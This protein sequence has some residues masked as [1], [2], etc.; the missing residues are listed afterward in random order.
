MLADRVDVGLDVGSEMRQAV[1]MDINPEDNE[2]L[3]I[4]VLC[5]LLGYIV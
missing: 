3:L 5:I 2:C 4:D 1:F